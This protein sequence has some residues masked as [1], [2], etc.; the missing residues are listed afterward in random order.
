MKFRPSVLID[1]N[2]IL[3]ECF[4]LSPTSC[5]FTNNSPNIHIGT[6]DEYGK[7]VI[8]SDDNCVRPMLHA[9]V[10]I[11]GSEAMVH[12]SKRDVVNDPKHFR[13]IDLVLDVS[14]LVLFVETCKKLSLMFDMLLGTNHALIEYVKDNRDEVIQKY[15]DKQL[16][17]LER[18]L[19]E[20]YN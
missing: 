12:L 3:V 4:K 18:R 17:I 9:S 8:C 19:N 16:E 15:L 2:D 1:S 6:N 7:V 10:T 13:K 5:G 20:P 14:S 11:S